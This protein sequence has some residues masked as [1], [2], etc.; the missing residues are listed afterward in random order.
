MID[1]HCHILPGLDDGA[2]DL[3]TALDMARACVR[4]GVQVVVCTPHILPGLYHNT[5]SDIRQA[6][7]RMQQALDAEGIPLT[8]VTGADVHV[9]PDLVGGLRSGR[10]L[11]IADSRYVLIEPPHHV[12]P[13][14]LED[15]FFELLLAG[16]VPVLTHPERLS[17]ISK[18]YPLIQRLTRSGVWMQITAGSLAGAFGREARYWSERMLDEGCVHVLATDAHG[19]DRRPPDLGRGRELA[20]RRIGEAGALDLVWTRPGGVL[21]NAPPTELP[22]PVPAGSN[23]G[24]THVDAGGS[25]RDEQMER[26]RGRALGGRRADGMRGI[27]GR[28]RR[29]L[30]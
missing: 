29:I 1:L 4:D 11:S 27:A 2:A 17:W 15:A 13:I 7:G 30:G 5:G 21:A 6:T 8:L 12:A 22:A 16:Y 9:A 24:G 3:A 25:S 19:V 26:G 18:Q 10:L 28:L 14:R 20:A 23:I